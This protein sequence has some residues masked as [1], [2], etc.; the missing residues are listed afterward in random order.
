MSKKRI[1]HYINQFFAGIG[2]EEKADVE[3]EKRDGIVGPGMAF[4]AQLKDV[5][6][7]VGT[8]ICG[9]SYFSEHEA[10]ASDAVL[11]MIKSYDPDIVIVG[12]SFNAGRYGVAAGAVAKLVD[13][14]LHI[15]VVGGM[16]PENPGFELYKQHGYF[17]EVGNSAATMRKAIPA[18]SDV[19]KQIID[20]KDKI[21]GYMPKGLRV[22]VFK[23]E[24]GSK[25]AVEMLLD[26]IN[27]KEYDTEYPM[28]TFDR[29]D[30]APAVKDITKARIALVSSGGPVPKGNPD[31]I[32]S[33]S[34]SKYGKYSL[35][36][37]DDLTPENS[38]TAHGG[39]DP[40]YANEDLDRVLP[41]DVIKEMLANGEIGSLHDYWYATV[42][43][44]TSVANAKKFGTE[45]AKQLKEDGV[46]A[47]ILTST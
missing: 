10:D 45:I 15:P 9:D 39:Y 42:G 36:D 11:E 7:I 14:N 24:R 27:G 44:G 17:V 12:P 40:V 16:Y 43:N 47:V 26:K 6:E 8:V 2:G 19:V 4:N 21:T 31:H 32:E 41:V 35:K 23:K 29:V 34:A 1:V 38:Q 28:P 5:A 37:I 20:G 33:S 18:M 3:P 46:D 13:E 25:R 22:N 30:P